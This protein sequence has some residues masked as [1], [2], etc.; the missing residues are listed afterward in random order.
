MHDLGTLPDGRP[1]LAMKLIKGTT[2]EA[3]LA[4]RPD[5]SLVAAF[6][7]VC[8][9][10]AYAHAHGVIHRDLKPA[11]VMLGSFGEVQ[12]MDWGL[13]K[14]LRP[15]V[16]DDPTADPDATTLETRVESSVGEDQ[17][18]R[19]GSVMGTPAY[20]PPEQAIGAVDQID[21]RSDVFGLGGILAQI[22]TGRPPLVGGD[23][24]AVRQLAARGKVADCF[25]RLDGCGADPELVAL[26]KRCLA[27]EEGRPSRRRGRGG[28]GGGRA[29]R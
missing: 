29:A 14:L 6:E 22:L 10:V 16:G 12:V 8:H 19:A 3:R 21:R 20:M 5:P 26:C 2:L 7:L 15:V 23:S 4:G 25:A 24:E 13:A 28:E 11:N 18:T 1:F 27:P 17:R 9:A